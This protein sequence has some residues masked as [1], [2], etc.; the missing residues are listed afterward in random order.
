MWGRWLRKHFW[1]RNVFH[2]IS[3]F[4]YIIP[5]CICLVFILCTCTSPLSSFVHFIF[6]NVLEVTITVFTLHSAWHYTVCHWCCATPSVIV[7][8]AIMKRGTKRACNWNVGVSVGVIVR[9]KA[10]SFKQRHDCLN[11]MA[12]SSAVVVSVLSSS[13]LHLL[14]LSSSSLSSL[15]R[16]WY[17]MQLCCLWI[18]PL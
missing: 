13:F 5:N 17:H 1:E 9:T 8:N 18:W 16:K 6:L 3:N 2:A 4:P 15:K 12:T 11:K 14:L 7:Y 10:W